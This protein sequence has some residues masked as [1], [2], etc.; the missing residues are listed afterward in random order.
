[1][2]KRECFQLYLRQFIFQFKDCEV[3]TLRNVTQLR[4]VTQLKSKAKLLQLYNAGFSHEMLGPLRCMLKILETFKQSVSED[5]ASTVRTLFNTT[6]FLLNHVQLNMDTS[7]LEQNKFKPKLDKFR[8]NSDIVQPVIE[9]FQES[10]KSQEVHVMFKTDL[11]E[12]L[13]LIDKYR[14]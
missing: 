13:Q 14:V 9:L 8:L 11:I 1:M 5:H 6:S 12:S 2:G 10:A 4:K 7:M 3:L